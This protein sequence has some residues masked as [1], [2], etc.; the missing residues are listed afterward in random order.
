A[1]LAFKRPVTQRKLTGPAIIA[2][3]L[4]TTALAACQQG[5]SSNQNASGTAVTPSGITLDNRAEKD[6]RDA[7]A[8]GAIANGLKPDLFLKGGESGED[9]V[10]AALKYASALATGYSDPTKLHEVY[11]LDRPKVDVR[12]RLQQALQQGKVA[13]WFN[14]LPPQTDE[15]K[16][17][18]QA[19]VRY[20]KQAG[21]TAQQQI[22]D[23]KPIKPGARDA[24]IP[25][26]VAVLRSGGYVPDEQ[27][28]QGQAQPQGQ[29][30][31]QAAATGVYTP[32]LVAAVK[33]F[34]ADSGTKPDGVLGKET[35][36]ALSIGPA[37][38]ARQLAVAMERL[39]WLP[40]NPPETRIDVNTAASFLD[41]WRD[42]QHV[43]HRKVIDGEPDKPTPQLQGPIFQLVVK[44]VWNI[45]EGI[46]AKEL[47]T[48]SGA[49]LRAN[50]YTQKDGKWIQLSGPK[51]SLGLVKF[52]MRDPEAIYL[53]D[54]PAKAVFALPDRHRSHGCVRVENAVQFATALAEQEGVLDQFQQAMQKDDQTF[55]KLPQ[56]IPVRLLYHTA[57]WD[58]SRVQF[59]PDVYGWDENIAKA[60]E[61]APGPPVKIEQPESSDDIGP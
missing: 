23:D 42:G 8:N 30:A 39:R 33:Q 40:R 5:S 14:S 56:E 7:I 29:G 20:A 54:T 34:Q 19:F 25:A 17:L 35:I 41:Y 15:Y 52:D 22:P 31:Q 24:R 3:A 53:H 6:I 16:A 18:S 47:A 60:L 44:P 59:R 10:Q 36:D 32:A 61:F 11:T 50:G 48:K 1:I 46:A 51:N 21:H 45:P 26:I 12:A 4:C 38:R 57:F 28:Q 49:W 37:A 13:D 43:D 58:G 27:P 2:L 55:I 9:L